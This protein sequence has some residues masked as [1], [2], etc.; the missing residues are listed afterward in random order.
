[1][2]WLLWPRLVIG[3]YTYIPAL[4]SSVDFGLDTGTQSISRL[5]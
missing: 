2:G 5:P 3:D 4:S 1:M